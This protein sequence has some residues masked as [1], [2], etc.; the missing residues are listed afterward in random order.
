VLAFA[1]AVVGQL[2]GLPPLPPVPHGTW[3]CERSDAFVGT[4]IVD[5]LRY[6]FV[7]DAGTSEV[8]SLAV[9]RA[10]LGS[11]SRASLVR[12]WS[13]PLSESFG[14]SLGFHNRAAD[15]E[16]LVFSIGPGE[17]LECLRS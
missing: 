14:I 17:G 15:P 9:T 11:G 2:V 13:G 3:T 10:R 12:V 16:T 8:G 1:L 5:G 7:D 4:L 6:V